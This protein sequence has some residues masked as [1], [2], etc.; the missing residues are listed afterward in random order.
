MTSL[1]LA[2]LGLLLGGL[3]SSAMAAYHFFLPY[4]WNWNRA[5]T[6]VPPAIQ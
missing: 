3:G 6:A 2:K 4:L 1:R 5:L